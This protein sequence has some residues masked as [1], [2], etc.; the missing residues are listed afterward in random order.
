MA[1]TVCFGRESNF[2]YHSLIGSSTIGSL[3]GAEED[4]DQAWLDKEVKQKTLLMQLRIANEIATAKIR[5]QNR[6]DWR[7]KYSRSGCEQSKFQQ[8]T[9]SRAARN[10]SE[11]PAELAIKEFCGILTV[12]E[13]AR[14]Q[15]LA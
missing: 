7:W 4:Q 8:S 3:C 6:G 15:V 10:K 2:N 12:F 1:S 5:R 14:N 11:W 13:V 9:G